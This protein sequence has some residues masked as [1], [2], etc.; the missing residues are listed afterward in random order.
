MRFVPVK[1]LDE[2]A[3]AQAYKARSLLVAQRTALVNALRAHLTEF[4]IVAPVGPAG[5]AR[6][7]ALLRSGEAPIPDLGRGGARRSVRHHRGDH[8]QGRRI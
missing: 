2:Q 5:S 1:S 7:I 4:G 8:S 3:L 6:L